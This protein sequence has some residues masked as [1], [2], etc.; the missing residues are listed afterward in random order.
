M[1]YGSQAIQLLP[2]GLWA[3]F[4]RVLVIAGSA[5]VLRSA[6]L[7]WRVLW[8]WPAARVWAEGGMASRAGA[9]GGVLFGRVDDVLCP[10]GGEGSSLSTG[11]MHVQLCSFLCTLVT[12]CTR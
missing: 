2:D 4:D 5:F 8:R 6:G 11:V 7:G 1:T 10:R 12:K 9:A 3:D